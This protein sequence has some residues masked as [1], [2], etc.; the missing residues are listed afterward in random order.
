VTDLLAMGLQHLGDG[1][2][3][4]P[5]DLLAFLAHDRVEHRQ[6]HERSEHFSLA[7]D[8]AD[9]C[10]EGLVD[11]LLERCALSLQRGEIGKDKGVDTT[12]DALL[13]LV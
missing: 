13:Y 10:P 3:A 8:V 2:L 11:C 9:E 4:L 7:E 1:P 6:H 5:V 12:V